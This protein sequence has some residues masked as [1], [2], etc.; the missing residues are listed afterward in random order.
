MHIDPQPVITKD[1]VEVNVDGLIW[2]RP[3]LDVEEIKKRFIILMTGK[4]LCFN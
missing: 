3:G 1:N 2:V 4:T